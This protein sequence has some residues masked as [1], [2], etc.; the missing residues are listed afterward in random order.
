MATRAEKSLDR[1][2]SVRI[3]KGHVD[4]LP[5][6]TTGQAFLRD[7]ELK[8]FIVRVTSGGAKSCCL[9]KRL[10]GRKFR[11]K[12]GV[13]PEMSVERARKLAHIWLG[14]IAEGQNPFEEDD[15]AARAKLT[16]AFVLEDYLTARKGLRPKTI[17]EY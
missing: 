13:Y 9:E 8:G 2:G 10:K 14:Q 6:P 5:A 15:E 17:A 4:R 12:I 7:S 16:L 11:R 1:L 3:T